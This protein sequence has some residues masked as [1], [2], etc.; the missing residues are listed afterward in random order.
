MIIKEINSFSKWFKIVF[1]CVFVIYIF[2]WLFT[3][4]LANIQK[5]TNLE[6]ILPVVPQD[7][8]EYNELAESIIQNQSFYS[9]GEINTLRSP[10]YPFFVAIL[11]V[12]SGSYFL[13]TF[14]Q[15]LLVFGSVVIIRRLGALFHSHKV[16]EIAGIIFILNPLVLT[17]SLIILTDILFLFLFL[18]GFYLAISGHYNIKRITFISIIFALAIYVRPMGVFALPIFAAPF[19]ASKLSV[20]E[21]IKS[22]LVMIF[23][24]L[25]AVSPWIYRNYK[26]TRVA[27]F[28]SF[29]AINLAFYAVPMFLSNLNQTNVLEERINIENEVGIPQSEWRK[30]KYSKTLSDYS[31]KII[32]KHPFTYLKYHITTSLPFLFS[33]SIQDTIITYKSAMQIK[34]KFKPGAIRYLVSEQWKL[35]FESVTAVWW[36][37]AERMFWLTA[38]VVTIGVVW[39][40]RKRKMTWAFIFIPVYLMLLAGPAANARYAVQG[41]PFVLILF[42]VGVPHIKEKIKSKYVSR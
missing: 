36:K 7:S 19:L 1:F 26:S 29:K 10:G 23:V 14:V 24:V 33:S 11:K 25:I 22:L 16:G 39:K 13:V 41:L 40:E 9:D 20:K 21:K 32:L 12:V 35:L 17:L 28:T 38:Y 27:D 31:Q 8:E 37:V 6:P 30:L 42:S 15:I 4:Y 2:A 3:I 34:D 18:I 5:A